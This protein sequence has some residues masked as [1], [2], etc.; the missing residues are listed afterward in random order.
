MAKFTVEDKMLAARKFLEGHDSKKEI[1]RRYGVD[2]KL[3]H[4]WIKLY[5]HHGEEGL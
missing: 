5:R 3:L 2:R 1:A 4:Q